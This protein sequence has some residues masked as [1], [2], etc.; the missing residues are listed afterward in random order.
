MV[1][2]H[3]D[4]ST[5]TDNKPAPHGQEATYLP[6]EAPAALHIEQ[7]PMTTPKRYTHQQSILRKAQSATTTTSAPLSAKRTAG[8]LT[9]DTLSLDSASDSEFPDA[10]SLLKTPVVSRQQQNA[11]A[12]TPHSAELNKAN[13]HKKGRKRKRVSLGK[14]KSDSLQIPGELVM[15]YYLRKYY[16]ARITSRVGEHRFRVERIFTQYE[17]GFYTCDLGVLQLIGD[18]PAEA[19]PSGCKAELESADI[20]QEFEDDLKTFDY[21]VSDLEKVRGFLDDLHSC[22]M[23]NVAE[24]SKTE[25]RLGIFFGGD[26][27][28]KRQLMSRVRRGHLNGLEFDFIGRLLGKWFKT[29]PKAAL[30][31]LAEMMPTKIP[32]S[33]KQARRP[34][35]TVQSGNLVVGFNHEVLLPHA[36]K[37]LIQ[38]RDTCSLEEAEDRMGTEQIMAIRRIGQRSAL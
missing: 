17:S 1:A 36:I 32:E 18:I 14:A 4:N 29:P 10:L 37:R 26:R 12:S 19:E 7:N 15:A 24:L 13:K 11:H 34:A 23:D 22:P 30:G 2:V 6:A 31:D 5:S 27:V 28:K 33:A 38:L 16:P 21:L 35:T 8:S 3:D 9:D 20:D 25:D